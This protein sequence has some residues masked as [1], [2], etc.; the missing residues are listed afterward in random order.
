MHLT[1]R[2][3]DTILSVALIIYGLVLLVSGSKIEPLRMKDDMS[4]GFFPMLIGGVL[5]LL[6]VCLLINAYFVDKKN[7][8][9]VDKFFGENIKGGLL[10]IGTFILYILL[11]NTVGFLISSVVYL[12]VQ[13]LILSDKTNRKPWIFA[14]IAVMFSVLVY[15]LFTRG[16]SLL[17]PK[18]LLKF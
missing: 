2:T 8:K 10:T 9:I 16:F 14:L 11:Y 12:F 3:K 1:R 18:G 7:A 15:F 13:M 17:L 6:A 5:I 4:S